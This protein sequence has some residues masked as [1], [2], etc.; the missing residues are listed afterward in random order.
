MLMGMSQERLGDALGLT[1]QQ[2]SEYERNE[3]DQCQPTGVFNS[4]PSGFLYRFSSK[5]AMGVSAAPE[6]RETALLPDVT[7]S[8]ATSE[9]LALVQ[10]VHVGQKEKAQALHL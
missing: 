1:F 3:P 10:S 2:S 9:G 7:C 4:H 6:A 5:G 8:L